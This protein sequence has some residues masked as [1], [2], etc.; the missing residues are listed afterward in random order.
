MHGIEREKLWAIFS[1]NETGF[2]LWDFEAGAK[3][4][5]L[6]LKVWTQSLDQLQQSGAPALLFL[7]DSGHI[8]TLTALNEERA[9]IMDK[10]APENLAR[11]DLAKRYFGDALVFTQ[12]LTQKAGIVAEDNVRAIRLVARDAEVAQQVTIHNRGEREVTLQLEAL[13]P[14]VTWAQLSAP[15]LAPGAAAT[16][17][18]KLKWRSVVRARGQNVLLAVRTNDPMA[19]RLQCAFLLVAP[20]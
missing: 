5:G 19:P 15:T 2:S 20:A 10:G 18:V 14:G 12:A 8:V 9:V 16:L 3:K 1:P 11:T 17:D 7:Q 4:L 13:A 6:N